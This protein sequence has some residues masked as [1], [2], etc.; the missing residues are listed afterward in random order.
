MEERHYVGACG[1]YCGLCPRFQSTAPSRCKG[2]QLGEQHTYCSVWKCAQKH[3]LWTCAD[4]AEYPCARL[5]RVLGTDVS[6]DSFLSHK[7]ALPN[8]DRIR[9]VG[10]DTYLREARQRRL[11][12][13]ELLEGYNDGRSMSFY[14][15]ACALMPPEVI[16][17]AIDEI[18]DALSRALLQ[19]ENPKARAKAM[20]A[21]IQ[22]LADCAQMDL[23][24][25]K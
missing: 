20:R 11:L 17:Q 5:H 13:E 25:R 1:L 19:G 16:R 6:K 3:G 12:V 22:E 15:L 14:C 4:C 24:L 2:C 8:L 10:L 18:K 23:K 21:T 9:A 7:P